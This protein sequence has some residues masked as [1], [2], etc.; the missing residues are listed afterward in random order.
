MLDPRHGGTVSEL[1]VLLP[2]LADQA[3]HTATT[4]STGPFFIFL[5]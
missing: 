5:A 2:P 4:G 1:T 3:P